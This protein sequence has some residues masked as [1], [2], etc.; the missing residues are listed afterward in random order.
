METENVPEET[1]NV[2]AGIVIEDTAVGAGTMIM[3]A[4]RD[5]MKVTDTM[6]HAANEGISLLDYGIG[7]LGGSPSLLRL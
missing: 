6:I 7:L 3:A 2:Q 5:I 1:G 4:E